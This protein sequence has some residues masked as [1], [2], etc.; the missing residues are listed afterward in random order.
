MTG[1]SQELWSEHYFSVED[2]TKL[3]W[4]EMGSGTPVILIHGAGGSAVGNW[5]VNGVAPALAAT[6]RVIGI[7]MRGHGMSEAGPDGTQFVVMDFPPGKAE[8]EPSAL[9]DMAKASGNPDGP[10]E[11]GAESPDPSSPRSAKK[12][13]KSKR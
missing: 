4:V 7:D 8:P 13:S 3:H 11:L 9:R 5:F 1:T 2:G 12:T 10:Q 6:N